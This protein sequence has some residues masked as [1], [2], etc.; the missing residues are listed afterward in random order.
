[1]KRLPHNQFTRILALILTMVLLTMT[2][3]GCFG[4]SDSTEPSD[5]PTPT[6]TGSTEATEEA[7]EAPTEPEE[8][9]PEIVMGTVNTDKLNVRTKANANA[10]SVNK[11]AVG[12]RLEILEQ[13]TV[14]DVTWGRIEEGWVNMKFVTL[15]G[16]ETEV[17]EVTEAPEA[18]EPETTNQSTASTGSGKM[19]TITAESL[20][21]R[22]GPGTKYDSVGKVKKGDRVE[23]LETSGN[24]GKT[25]DGWISLKYV[26]MD[27]GSSNTST[28]TT[29]SSSTEKTD[30]KYSTLVTNGSTT[31]LGT[32]K[33]G[34]TALNVRYGP[35]TDYN[36]LGTV[37]AGETLTY[38]QKSGNWIRISKG[39]IS[40]K[41]VTEV[42]SSSD[43]SS[44]TNSEYKTGTGKVTASA[45]FIRK[46]AGTT[47]DS[48]GKLYEGDTVEILEVSGNW[49]RISEGW[50]CLDYVKMN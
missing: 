2:F 9:E 31:A 10:P 45:L 28:E 6:A 43:N 33:V 46:G 40:Y 30:S 42:T 8:T 12:T 18:T 41:Y 7:T 50:I 38:Y 47:Y 17:P 3:T 37:K 32:V 34:D 36:K 5:D 20:N 29:T 24:W 35:S 21:V 25:A 26:K 49:G 13:L 1:M 22:K 14:D 19:G 44:G 23:I 16:D 48:V 4:N 39:W 27:D 15:D 11:L